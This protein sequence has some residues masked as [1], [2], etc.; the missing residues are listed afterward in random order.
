MRKSFASSR[1]PCYATL[2]GGGGGG[3]TP[4]HRG[5]VDARRVG[6]GGGLKEMLAPTTQRQLP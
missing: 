2:V 5:V 3:C 6:G 4:I 1:P